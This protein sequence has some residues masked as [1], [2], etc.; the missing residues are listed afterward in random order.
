[1]THAIPDDH[2]RRR[3]R[4]YPAIV[5]AAVA[6]ALVVPAVAQAHISLHPNV[7]PA[8]SY[9]T[10]N[11]R[12]PGEQA[13][14]HVTELD[15]L[16]PSGFTSVDYQPV[17][18]WTVSEKLTKLAKPIQ[19]DDGPISDEISQIIWKWTGPLGKI[20]DGQ[21]LQFP[22]SIAI[23]DND[24]GKSLR[25]KAV[26][27]YS[28]GQVVRWI[29][30]GLDD[31]NPAP[32]INVS[33]KGG[34]LVDVAGAEAGPEP[35]QTGAGNAVATVAKSSGGASKGLAIVALIVGALGLIVGLVAILSTRRVRT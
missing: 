31:Q 10:L 11:V 20:S 15:M 12:M 22:L 32:T 28:N 5:V 25:F 29:Q 8:G 34:N 13:N 27:S 9:A 33:A 3:H 30:P 6:L 7:V 4:R 24:A 21:F 26:Q 1:M 2:S 17:P 18:G 23:P 19:S 16:L 35:G 14:A